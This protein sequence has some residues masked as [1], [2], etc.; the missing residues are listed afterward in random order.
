MQLAGK[1]LAIFN[2]GL[3]LSFVFSETPEI[4]IRNEKFF[5]FFSVDDLRDQVDLK[6]SLKHIFVGKIH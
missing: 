6:V 3:S 4:I 1:I 2:V 5:L